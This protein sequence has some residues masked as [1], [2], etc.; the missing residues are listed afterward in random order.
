MDNKLNKV[1]M[2]KEIDDAL[3]SLKNRYILACKQLNSNGTIA[4]ENGSRTIRSRTKR[5]ICILT[6][7]KDLL[8][9]ISNN[10]ISLSEDAVLG[11]DKIIKG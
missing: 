5:D 1:V 10:N 11:F 3:V 4:T 8:N 9:S 2:L 7:I 6:L